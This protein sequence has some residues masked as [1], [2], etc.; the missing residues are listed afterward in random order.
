MFCSAF[1]RAARVHGGRGKAASVGGEFP[2]MICTGDAA[3]LIAAEKQVGAAMR[4]AR[5]DDPDGAVSA[6]EGAKV[7]AQDLDAQRRAVR[8]RQLGTERHR[9]PEWRKTRPSPFPGRYG[10]AGRYRLHSAS[11]AS[12]LPSYA[13]WQEAGQP[14][15]DVTWHGASRALLKSRAHR[16]R[17]HPASSQCRPVHNGCTRHDGWTNLTVSKLPEGIQ[18][19]I[20]SATKQSRR[21]THMA[22]GLL[23]RARNDRLA[24]RIEASGSQTPTWQQPGCRRP[25]A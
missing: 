1:S 12:I 23:R 13:G 11:T 20:A 5:G 25:S 17:C 22:S 8:F 19:F 14:A 16:L 2:A 18:S 7:F 10:S 3:V 9:L 24:D 4:T 6:A 21:K 15:R